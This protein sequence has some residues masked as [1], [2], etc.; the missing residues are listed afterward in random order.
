MWQPWVSIRS[1]TGWRH[2]HDFDRY[3]TASI[4][5]YFNNSSWLKTRKA[6]ASNF[7]DFWKLFLNWCKIS[8]QFWPGDLVENLCR[9]CQK[10]P[11]KFT[12]T[13]VDLARSKQILAFP[14]HFRVKFNRCDVIWVAF[15]SC[16]LVTTAKLRFDVKFLWSH[17]FWRRISVALTSISVTGVNHNTHLSKSLVDVRHLSLNCREISENWPTNVREKLQPERPWRS[18]VENRLITPAKQAN[19]HQNLPDGGWKIEHHLIVKNIAH[20]I[21]MCVTD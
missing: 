21:F 13:S 2:S 5:H 14:A 9:I 18:P 7:C 6:P 15:D 4:S 11:A 17:Q 1:H 16:Q 10:L 20:I 12:T 19:H 8:G 3:S